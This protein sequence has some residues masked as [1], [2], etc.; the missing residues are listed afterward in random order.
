[1]P[2]V[3]TDVVVINSLM[4]MARW[5]RQVH[6]RLPQGMP[7]TSRA[8]RMTVKKRYFQKGKAQPARDHLCTIDVTAQAEAVIPADF[9]SCSAVALNKSVS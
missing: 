5:R 9:W 4:A 7:T 1:M 2:S 8:R 6:A 3:P